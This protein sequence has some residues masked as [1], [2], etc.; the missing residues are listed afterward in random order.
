MFEDEAYRICGS[1]FL[2]YEAINNIR[3]KSYIIKAVLHYENGKCKE[4][5]VLLQNYRYLTTMLQCTKYRS[6]ASPLMMKTYVIPH[7]LERSSVFLVKPKSNDLIHESVYEVNKYLMD[8]SPLYNEDIYQ[9]HNIYRNQ[10][11]IN[12]KQTLFTRSSK[13]HF[14]LLPENNRNTTC[15]SINH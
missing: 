1:I 15:I 5:L 9:L 8:I 2:N 14:W 11:I 10:I 3:F 13:S 4:K 6:G 7:F 12:S